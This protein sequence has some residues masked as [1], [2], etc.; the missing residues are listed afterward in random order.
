MEAKV[1]TSYLWYIANKTA[2]KIRKLLKIFPT[3]AY[4]IFSNAWKI[5][6]K[7]LQAELKAVDKATIYITLTVCSGYLK[8]FIDRAI[9]PNKT[10]YKIDFIIAIFP[11]YFLANELFLATSLTVNVLKPNSGKTPSIPVKA[12]AKDKIPK[13]STPR[14]LPVYIT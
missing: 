13:P 5:E 14:Y 8:I 10:I 3:D 4:S 2:A 9:N 6:L 1:V 12:R 11:I 7:I